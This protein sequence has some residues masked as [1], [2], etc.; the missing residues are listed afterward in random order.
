M[1]IARP[2]P[3]AL[4]ALSTASVAAATLVAAPVP[5]NRTTGRAHVSAPAAARSRPAPVAPT[6]HLAARTSTPSAAPPP[7][8]SRGQALPRSAAPRA[9]GR[10]T[11]PVRPLRV[12][13]R[14]TAPPQP[15]ARGHR[16]VDLAAGPGAAIVAPADGVVA[17]AGMV[18]GRPVLSVDHEGGLRS[19]Y[20]PVVARVSVGD[21]VT[22]GQVIA[23]VADGPG[24]CSS[25]CLHWGARRGQVYVDPLSLI[26]RPPLVL[27]PLR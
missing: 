1:P 17:F 2:L 23:V 20:E 13:T 12:V 15:W 19:T 9:P 18:A 7:A 5:D 6:A 4:V 26:D 3:T 16:G 10:W 14:F 11:A 22:Q 8:P 27:L 24:H 21:Q 25:S